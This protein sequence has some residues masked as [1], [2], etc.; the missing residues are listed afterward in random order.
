[1][2]KSVRL[3]GDR[4]D[5]VRRDGQWGRHG[6]GELG[7]P[8]TVRDSTLDRLH[9]LSGHAR[10]ILRASAVLG[11]P[12]DEV[13]LAEVA[14]LP[15][16]AAALAQLQL[17]DGDVEAALRT[18]ED[19]VATVVTKRIWIWA[20]GLAQVRVEALARAGR[21][22][23][24]AR[25]VARLTRGLRGRDAP[26]PQAAAVTC[27]AVLAQHCGDH[28][29][30]ADRFERAARRWDALPRPYDAQLAR[31]RRADS[32]AAAGRHDRAAELRDRVRDR[33]HALGATGDADRVR[34]TL[35]VSPPASRWRG[36]S[37]GY[38][39]RLSPREEE[40]VALV[41]SGRTNR[42]VARRLGKSPQTVAEQLRSA[43]RKLGAPSRTALA[44]HAVA[45]GLVPG[46]PPDAA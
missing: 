44:V 12:A 46:K 23:E 16:P 4:A 34:D 45:A 17:A 36:G 9:R 20:D 42:E 43:M 26:G 1:M 2:E 21:R 14:E 41:V 13:T 10:R 25:L 5:L 24:A 6:A 27:R 18:T 35:R 37:R 32:L 19:L 33:L 28:I 7:V 11:E 15:E 30:A 22:D 3:L 31:E 29:G 40:V 38:G 39:E 8:P